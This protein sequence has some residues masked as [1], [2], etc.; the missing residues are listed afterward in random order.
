MTS[1]ASLRRLNA[2]TKTTVGV[3]ADGAPASVVVGR[4]TRRVA[5]VHEH[6]RID[7][8]WWWEHRVSRLYWRL[9]LDD[10]RLLTVYRDL[11]EGTWW[12][13]RA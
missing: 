1:G 4:R 10:G 12:T 2:P 9:V 7:E 6:W 13:Q 5:S 8:G 11:V 3:G